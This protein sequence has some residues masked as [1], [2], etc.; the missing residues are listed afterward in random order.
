MERSAVTAPA[1]IEVSLDDK[2][3]LDKAQVYL[4]GTQALV[5]LCLMQR[6]RDHRAGLR[7]AG[8]VSGYRGS[9]LGGVDQQ[10]TRAKPVLSAADINFQ[11]GLN[12]DLAATAVWGTQQATMRGEGRVDGV[13]AVW[14]GKGPGVDRTGDVFRHANLAG[15]DPRGGVMALLGDDHVAE[16]STTAHQSEFALV[17]AMMPI[18]SPAGVQEILDYGLYG[19]ALSR[20]SSTWVGLKCVKDTVESTTAVDG[21]LDRVKIVLPADAVLPADGLG[22]RPRDG[23]LEQEE[24]LHRYKRAAVQAFTRANGLDRLVLDGGTTPRIGVVS[25]GKS[26]L[27]V[28]QALQDLGLDEAGAA[29]H[30]LRLYKVGVTWP[31]EPQGIIDFADGLDLVMVIEEK[32]GLIEGQMREILYGRPDAPRIIGKQDEAGALLFP[33]FGALEVNQVALAI[34]QRLGRGGGD[35]PL[36]NRLAVIRAAQQRLHETEDVSSR[37]PYFCAGCPHNSSTKVPDGARAYAGIGCHYMSQWMDRSTEGYTHMGGEG[38]SWVGESGF[39]TRGHMIQNLGDGTYNHSGSLALRFAAGTGVNITYKILFNDAVAMTGGQ[40]HDGGLTVPKIAAQVAAEGVAR[41]VVVTDEPDKYTADTLWPKGLEI[42]HRSRLIP[43]QEE[44]AKVAGVTVLIYD[45]TCAAEKRR[46]RKRGTFPDPDRRIIINEQVCEGCG[47]CGVQSNCI[48]VQP[49]ETPLGRKRQIDQSACNKDFSCVEGFCPSFVSVEGAKLRKPKAAQAQASTLPALP[50]PVLPAINGTYNILV[51]GVGGTGVVTVGAILSMAAHLEGKGFGVID[52]AGLAQKG[53]AVYS[54]IRIARRPADITA[55]RIGAGS[56]D[57]LFGGDIAVAGTA[58]ALATIEHGRT[59]VVVNTAEVLPGDFTRDVDYSLPVE[60]VKRSLGEAAGHGACHFIDANQLALA[61]L[62]NTIGANLFLLGHAWQSGAIP[63]SKAALDRAI[64]VNGEAVAM[65]KAAFDWGRHAAV[66]P[67]RLL[68]MVDAQ[69]RPATPVAESLDALVERHATF[70]TA[71]QNAAYARR[72]RILVD[73]VRAADL[74]GRTRLTEAVARN[75][76]K[77]M[78]YKDEYEVARLYTDGTFLRQLAETFEGGGL[79]L[80]FHMAPPVLARRDKATGRPRKSTFGPWM[81]PA[82]RVLARL[83]VLR[84]TPLD[85]FGYTADRR[86]ERKLIAD[87]AATVTGL[88]P[89]LMPA[90][91]E[92]AVSLAA[93]PAKI[94]GYGPVKEGSIV[95]ARREEAAL[96]ARFERKGPALPEAGT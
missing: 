31:L 51:T 2:Y 93:L 38:A 24:R 79:R 58:K 94:R 56:A 53:G 6:E 22:I 78:A 5:R 62:G 33:S 81:M 4:T 54:H 82:F 67:D 29:A 3:D 75:L 73:Q 66:H 59:R 63:L 8:F 83:K 50:E 61:L 41:I 13:F 37:T 84:G 16:S 14:Y 10:F 44:L 32:R 43:V 48:A 20:F 7:T 42:H 12:E 19:F 45:Q 1:L 52:M 90:N 69:R 27:D 55:I 74:R 57:L 17:D 21:S 89:R 9:P 91:Y 96:L 23:F 30:G 40:P 25:T 28:R 72:Y 34:G 39:S 68:A 35:G 64:E 36:A 88:L 85:P 47:D 70:L 86:T 15:T 80:R 76:F 46:R 11:P 60:R 77:L 95:T 92:L 49:V 26:Y 71:Y 87:Y 18:L 65:N